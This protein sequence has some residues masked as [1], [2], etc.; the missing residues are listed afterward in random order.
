MH[1]LDPLAWY[2]RRT[3]Y[4]KGKWRLINFVMGHCPRA[5]V[6]YRLMPGD[7]VIECRLSIPY[8][9]M[10][11]LRQ[12][13]EQEL[14]ALGRL[15]S[16]GGTFIDCGA[17]IGLWTLTAAAAVGPNGRVLAFEPAPSTFARLKR[18]VGGRYPQVHLINAAVGRSRSE[19]SFLCPDEHNLARV[20]PGDQPGAV[21]VPGTTID[22]AVGDWPVTGTKLDV[23]GV[24]FE[25][26]EGAAGTL[27][28][29]RPWLIVEFNTLHAGLTRLGD[30]PVHRHLARL[31]YEARLVTGPNTVAGQVLPDAWRSSGYRNLLYT[32]A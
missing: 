25:A 29:C 10:V 7:G 23:E 27:T 5:G 14:M 3:P 13:E 8:E 15:L 17:N 18:H 20:V 22:E 30:W 1:P 24:E 32:A 16:P 6:R 4:F 11:W 28:R 2:I 19:V 9:V 21:M 12:E 26:L 31:G